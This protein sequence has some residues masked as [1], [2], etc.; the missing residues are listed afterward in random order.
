MLQHTICWLFFQE[1]WDGD[2]FLAELE[3]SCTQVVSTVSYSH[4]NTL[5][6]SKEI[7][8]TELRGQQLFDALKVI[9]QDIRLWESK[10]YNSN[11]YNVFSLL[12]TH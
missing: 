6:G 5:G 12:H 11:K 7:Y 3:H 1:L 4:T 2:I 10:W 9:E 8:R